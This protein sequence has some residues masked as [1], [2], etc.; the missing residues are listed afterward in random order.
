MNI[1]DDWGFSRNPFEQTPLQ[2]DDIGEKLLI[3]RERELTRLM[4]LIET[5]PRLP[6]VE[7]LNG[8]G[9]TSLVNVATYRL[10]KESLNKTRSTIHPLQK[11]FSVIPNCQLRRV[12]RRNLS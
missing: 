3:G 12:H 7:G 5:G 4:S 9:K 8:V 11:S 1:Y 10:M 6:T 2:A